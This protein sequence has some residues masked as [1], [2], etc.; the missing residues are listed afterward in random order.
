ML[1]SCLDTIIWYVVEGAQC[2]ISWFLFSITRMGHFLEQVSIQKPGAQ[3]R[4]H[5]FQGSSLV[6]QSFKPGTYQTGSFL[7]LTPKFQ[8]CGTRSRKFWAP[9]PTPNDWD[10]RAAYRFYS[11]LCHVVIDEVSLAFP[12]WCKI[13]STQRNARALTI[14]SELLG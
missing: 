2:Q 12:Q 9:S 1:E 11:G 8:T 7:E 3:P 6:L 5:Y 13:S 4:T 14:S 10:P